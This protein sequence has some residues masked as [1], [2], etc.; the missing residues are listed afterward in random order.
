MENQSC[1][2]NETTCA[3][4]I[5]TQVMLMIITQTFMHSFSFIPLMT[6]EK[7]IFDFFFGNL[8]FRLP[9]QPIKINDLDKIQ[10]V[11]RRLLQEH[12]CKTFV[13]ISAMRFQFFHCKS[14][15]TLSCHSN[16]SA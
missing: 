4:A 5:K 14:M 16:Q 6:S 2:S 13:I 1:H 9:W 15:E 7:K 12:F 10:T 11:C 3:T 8:T